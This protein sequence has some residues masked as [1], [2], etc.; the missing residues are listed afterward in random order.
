MLVLNIYLAL[1]RITVIEQRVTEVVA[2]CLEVSGAELIAGHLPQQ[3]ATEG[4]LHGEAVGDAHL[5][6]HHYTTSTLLARK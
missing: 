1:V 2:H 5:S 4:S 6:P 3:G